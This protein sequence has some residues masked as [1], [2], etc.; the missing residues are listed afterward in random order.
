MAAEM[1][2]IKIQNQQLLQLFQQNPQLV[3]AQ[4]NLQ[5]LQ[6]PQDNPETQNSN[7]DVR[8]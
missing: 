1:E 4:E 5:L 8:R 2:I 7:I 3:Q 6:G